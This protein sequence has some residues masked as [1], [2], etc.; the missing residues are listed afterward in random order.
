MGENIYKLSRREEVIVNR[1]RL[2]H[3]RVT[4]GYL[5]KYEDGFIHQPMCR[6]CQAELLSIEY[7]LLECRVL[8][9]VRDEV[10][11]PALYNRDVN[12]RNLIGENGIITNATV[13]MREMG[14]YSEI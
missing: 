13:Y 9:N 5:F 7:I 10:L 11:G 2:G 4:H 14:I 6:W 1:L 3:T 12:L 8:K